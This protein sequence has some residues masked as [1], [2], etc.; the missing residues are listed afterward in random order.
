MN[1]NDFNF[2]ILAQDAGADGGSGGSGESAPAPSGGDTGAAPG[3]TEQPPKQAPGNNQRQPGFADML[4]LFIGMFVIMY[5]VMI[6]PQRKKQKEMQL[7]LDNMR[8]G[9]QVVSAGGIHGVI[10]N[11]TDTTVTVRVAQNVKMKFEKASIAKVTPKDRPM[12]DDEDDV[13]DEEE[14]FEEEEPRPQAK[15]KANAKK[16]SARK[17][18][19]SRKAPKKESVSL[20]SEKTEFD[21]S[22]GAGSEPE[23]AE[24]L[25]ESETDRRDD[26][27]P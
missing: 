19:A 4:P 24:E 23:E 5:F 16:K 1:H 6:R 7:M 17:K 20:R 27:R 25:E 2:T 26:S 12:D 10:T 3:T 22:G 14:D 15:K 8:V 13:V 11:K 21:R 18:R 9:D